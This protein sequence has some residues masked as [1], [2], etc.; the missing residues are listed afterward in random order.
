MDMRYARV[1]FCGQRP[2]LGRYCLHFHV[3]KKC[4]RCV[5]QGNA[6]VD[7][8]HVGITVHGTHDAV[9]EQ[10]IVWD[11]KANGLYIEDGNELRNTL[12]QNVM[13]CS[14]L[15]KCAVSWASGASSQT[16][17]IFM[18]GMSN[19]ILE[20]RVIGYENGIWT[21]GSFR[22]T[23]QGKALGKVCPQFYPFG[24]WRGNVCHDC[25]RF[26]LY[27]DHQYPR[28]VKIDEDGLLVDKDSCDWFTPEGR[29]NGFVNE[30]RD[31]LNWHNTYVGQ[32]AIGDIQFINYT[33]VRWSSVINILFC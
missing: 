6:V 31:E 25:N 13:I 1:E 17:G 29:D 2:V 10:N 16:A 15:K 18:I 30:V 11:A 8:E 7:G 32:Y 12:R 23:G 19:N 4:P 5:F 14:N 20:N 26:G 33:S 21:P 27:L 3:M 28:N 9:V 22:G 24:E